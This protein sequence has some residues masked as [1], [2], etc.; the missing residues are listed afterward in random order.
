MLTFSHSHIAALVK[1]LLQAASSEA[2]RWIQKKRHRV[3]GMNTYGGRGFY[4]L[5]FYAFL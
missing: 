2:C 1:G 4:G 5:G 3:G